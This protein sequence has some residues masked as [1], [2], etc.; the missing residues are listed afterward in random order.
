MNDERTGFH[1]DHTDDRPASALQ[2]IAGVS[3]ELYA[4]IVRSIALMNHDLSMLAP[5]AALH[6]VG[7][8]EW[9]LA[10]QGWNERI[11][12]DDAVNYLFRE[13]YDA[14]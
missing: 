1:H 12:A 13:L 14:G 6:G 2:P 10:R 3:L 11:A 8:D 5:M 7:H 9:V 4:R